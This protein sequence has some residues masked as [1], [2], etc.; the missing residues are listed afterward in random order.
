MT[1]SIQLAFR[2]ALSVA[3]PAT[4]DAL[5]ERMQ[6]R[7]LRALA[8]RFGLPKRMVEELLGGDARQMRAALTIDPGEWLLGAAELGDPVVGKALW[9][10]YFRDDEGGKHRAVQEIPDLLATLVHAADLSDPRWYEDDGLFPLLYAQ[11]PGPGLLPVLTSGLIGLH[12]GALALFAGHFPPPVVV[13]ACLSL[14]EEWGGTEPFTR[15]LELLDEEPDLDTGHPWLPDLLRRAVDAADPESLLREHRAAGEWEDPDHLR[16]LLELRYCRGDAVQPDGLDWELIR[17]EHARRPLDLRRLMRWEGCPDDLVMTRLREDPSDTVRHATD[18]PFEVLKEPATLD[19]DLDV[20]KYRVR[21]GQAPLHRV[22]AELAPAK[23]VLCAL[24]YDEE[25]TRKALAALVAPLGTDP[26]NWLTCYARLRRFRGSPTELIAEV[27]GPGARVKRRTDWPEPREAEFPLGEVRQS[28]RE[29]FLALLDSASQEAQTAVVPHLD[30]LGVQQFLVRGNPSPAV[31]DAA[32]AAHGRPAQLAMAA[33]QPGGEKRDYLLDLN[34]PE[35]DARYLAGWLNGPEQERLL[36]GRLRGGGTRPVPDELLAVLDELIVSEDRDKLLSGVDSGD[37][38]VARRV[39]GRLRLHLP[40]TR[41]RLLS[42]V[43]ERGGPDAVREILAM[44]R[45]PGA[46]T[47]WT[48]RLLEAPDGLV[49]LRSR[50]A[51]E[52]SPERLAAYVLR[53]GSRPE[54]RLKWLL[55]EE[56]EVPWAELVAAHRST[57]FAPELVAELVMLPRCPRELFLAWLGR[58]DSILG[59][60]LDKA[61]ERGT[62]RPEDFVTHAAPARTGLDLICRYLADGPSKEDRRRLRD[63]VAELAPERLGTN[64]DAWAVCLQLL[65]DFVGTLAE[66]MSTAGA[67]AGA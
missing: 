45:L 3:D 54:E 23:G 30:G 58:A 8:H 42:A 51:E 12:V 31:R 17:R 49:Q 43:W 10:A 46:L 7:L 34:D 19:T 20:L 26:V 67:A 53:P 36:A 18:L 39:V 14:L 27:T 40:A 25:P 48:E 66:L 62:L 57:P 35:I 6:P 41:L 60:L 9:N 15:F 13:D 1:D 63:K 64:P 56:L 38:G 21:D 11:R 16:G 52:K 59:Y 32:V 47:R 50:L 37:L 2:T 29:A 55:S 61:L 33:G 24:A 44:D 5:A 22:L 28:A 4:A 65:P